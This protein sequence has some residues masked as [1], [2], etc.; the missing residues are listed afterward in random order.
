M[1]RS[2]LMAAVSLPILAATAFAQDARTA[3]ASLANANGDAV[4]TVTVTAVPNGVIVVAALTG[5][6][7][8]TYAFHVHE[9]GACDA[10]TF[11]TAGGHFNPTEA[12]HGFDNEAGPHAGDL[13]NIH[14]P[15]SGELTVEFFSTMLWLADGEGGNL[16]DDDGAAVIIHAMHDD[17]M[18]DP[19]GNAG[20]RMICG[21]LAE[22]AV[23]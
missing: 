10:P 7:A 15:E 22:G 23:G 19:T 6:P 12:E 5:V 11:E 9:T 17:H 1:K 2:I 14:V 4:G 21:V 16:L 3:T 18:T 13:P 8:G 20:D